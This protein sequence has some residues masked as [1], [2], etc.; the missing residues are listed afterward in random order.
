MADR[1]A[2]LA[3]V[4]DAVLGIA[5]DLSLDVVLERL[6]HA[7]RSLAGA[8]YA[9]LGVPDDEGTGFARFITAGMADEEIEAM[10]PLPRTHGLLGAM[11]ADPE[12]YRTHDITQDPRF[13]GWWPS[14]HPRMRSFLGVPIV[15]KGD[16]IGAF[17]LTDKTGAAA[18]SDEDE[19]LIGVLS[20]HAAVLIEHARLYEQS[21]ELSVLDERNRLARELHDAM[22]Q[23][24]FSLRLTVETAKSAL[25]A[26]PDEAANQLVTAELLIGGLFD[27]LRSLILELRTP[28]LEVEG[29]VP[30]LRRHLGVVA[31][32]HNLKVDFVADSTLTLPPTVEREVFRIVQEAV[33][34]VVRHAEA[35][36]LR[37]SIEQ[38]RDG[39]AAVVQVQDDGAGFDLGAR[40]IRSRRLGLTS[41]RERAANLR[42]KLM[43]DSGR[44]SGTCVRL[45][46]PLGRG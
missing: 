35:S 18:F 32:A 23:H 41:M 26:A 46:V 25:R 28:D 7:G 21:R 34:N 29:L 4:S 38:D 36:L 33:T 9:A 10:G 31:R 1:G 2:A 40:A 42:A 19:K 39:R 20:A 3:A 14:T 8:R 24:L 15:F 12:P 30:A 45:E 37:V 11:L 27:E 6:V 5:G 44:G 16:V 17:Y 22:T 43:I 13:R